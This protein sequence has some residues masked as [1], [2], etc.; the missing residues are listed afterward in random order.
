MKWITSF[1][2]VAAS[3]TIAVVGAQQNVSHGR[4]ASTS[5]VPE[6]DYTD[7]FNCYSEL[8]S[9]VE[10]PAQESGPLVSLPFRKSQTVQVGQTLA[11]I[12]DAIAQLRLQTATTKLEAATHKASN[13]I[14]NRAA[15]NALNIAERERKTNYGLYAKG[16]LP[17]QD[18]ERSMLQAQQAALQLEQAQRDMESNKK[19]AQ[20]EGFNVS[21]A[22]DSIRRHEIKSPLDGNILELYKEAG[23]WVNAG[24]RVM[25]VGRLDRLYVYGLLKAELFDP[26]E[27]DGKPVTVTM[28]TARD[29][30]ASFQGKIVFVSY[31]KNSSL[32][33]SVYAEVEN[34]QVNGRW[35]LLSGVELSM[36]I[37]LKE[38]RLGQIPKTSH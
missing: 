8:I 2:L 6:K 31:E 37:H 16:A 19:N 4:P 10:I 20:V 21:A 12:D 13:D 36:R 34:R 23:E 29:Q 17:K 7:I 28:K 30:T 1:F 18:Y 32:G 22:E 9:D 11:K 33:Y 35:L 27:I 38:D 24:D 5:G 15:E 14:D 25:R 3:L 26:H